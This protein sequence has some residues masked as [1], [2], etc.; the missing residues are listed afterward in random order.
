MP[1]HLE[2]EKE[3][4]LGDVIISNGIVQYDFARQL[5]NGRVRKD[6]FDDNLSRPTQEIRY[7]LRKIEG[8]QSHMKLLDNTLL[9]LTDI[10]STR[11]FE[12]SKYL[13]T[14]EDKLYEITYRHKHQDLKDCGICSKCE[15]D[16]H[17]T[18]DKAL[19]ASCLQLKCED[20]RLVRRRRLSSGKTPEPLI[21]FGRFGS[22]DLV[23]KSAYHR[24]Q[25]SERE[26]IA[27]EME[28]AGVWDVFPSLVIKAVCDY[29][30]GHKNK[31][32]Q[33]YAAA[34]AAACTKACLKEWIVA[35]QEFESGE[36]PTL[37]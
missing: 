31:E 12:E 2:T 5:P 33:G 26:H 19:N 22:G 35:D 16:E 21:H 8:V 29:A 30:D 25:I 36:Y 34:T 6:A 20:K 28:G 7:F 27:F 32:W 24:D 15:S 37:P 9:H 1:T 18:C 10:C 17:D 23:M 3:I 11:G 14:N 13:G 4:I